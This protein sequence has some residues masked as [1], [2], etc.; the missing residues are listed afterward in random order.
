VLGDGLSQTVRVRPN[1]GT[2]VA[3]DLAHEQTFDIRQPQM[4]RPAIG[5]E[6]HGMTAAIV[7]AGYDDARGARLSRFSKGDL[8][9]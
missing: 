8:L 9:L 5:K 4:L 7:A 6:L 3:A 1:V 2:A